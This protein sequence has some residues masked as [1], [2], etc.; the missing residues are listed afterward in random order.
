M[1]SGTIFNPG[2]AY[3]HEC[4]SGRP[5]EIRSVRYELRRSCF[6]LALICSLVL[7]PD[8]YH[9]LTESGYYCGGLC[10]VGM[11]FTVRRSNGKMGYQEFAHELDFLI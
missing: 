4:E 7:P 9:R 2:D 10:A 1:S 8:T 3:I 6:A 5:I 11:T